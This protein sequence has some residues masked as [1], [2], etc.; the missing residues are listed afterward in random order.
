M[1]A[2][3]VSQEPHQVNISIYA[4]FWASSPITPAPKRFGWGAQLTEKLTFVRAATGDF[5]GYGSANCLPALG[6]N[7]PEVS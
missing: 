5:I 6:P 1:W 4:L 7:M 3:D 2:V